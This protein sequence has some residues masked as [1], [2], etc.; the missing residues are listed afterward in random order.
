MLPLHDTVPARRLPAAVWALVFV[1]AAIF[2]YEV[3]LGPDGLQ[4]FVDRYGMIP[5]DLSAPGG[6]ARHWPTVITSM[7]LH[8]S[9]LHIIGNMW[10][11]WIFGDNVEDR[12]GTARFLVFYFLGGFAAA[13]LQVSVDPTSQ[14][15]SIGASGAIAA[16]LGAYIVL[17]PTA[18]VISI[19]P[20][21]FLPMLVDVPAVLWIGFWFLEQWLNGFVALFLPAMGGVAWWAHIGGFL[22]GMA[23]AIPYRFQP[24][25][26]H[27]VGYDR[28]WPFG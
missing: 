19:V 27:Y 4:L 23:V 24:P 22:F 2:L 26:R 5:A 10:F 25:R 16:V 3:R 6:L 15:P 20:I 11:L 21:F 13:A 14:V 17:Y 28:E 9:W 18:T 1:N 7:F 8:G 12:L